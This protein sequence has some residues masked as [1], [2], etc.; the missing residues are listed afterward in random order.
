MSRLTHLGAGAFLLFGMLGKAP[1]RPP[2][3]A[4]AAASA[5][6][7]PPRA[8]PEHGKQGGRLG[9]VVAYVDGT[10]VAVVRRSELPPTM[11]PIALPKLDG[12]N[13]ARYFRLY[14]YVA[15]LGVDPTKVRA[16][17]LHGTRDRVATIEGAELARFKDALVFDFSQET[18]GKPR[19]RWS[20]PALAA[21]V[22]IDQFTA[23]AVYLRKPVP[24]YD[25]KT[26]ALLVEGSPA[27][28][29]PFA[30]DRPGGTRVYL[31]GKLVGW[32]KRKLLGDDLVTPETTRGQTVYDLSAF[33]A[34]LG[35]DLR[36][37]RTVD[38]VDGDDLAA[39]F[40]ARVP[41]AV[42]AT[43]WLPERS[44]GKVMI[45]LPGAGTVQISS[46]QVFARATPPARTVAPELG[47]DGDPEP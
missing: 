16:V 27:S 11:A 26:G 17:E 44:M 14:D 24:H 19:A 33:L 28:G 35:V 40:D 2:S 25:P 15:A 46:I 18:R 29:V 37:A 5:E 32:V 9:E 30:T 42:P 20:I 34:K 31:D 8:P 38:L 36:A 4:S 13:V 39:R 47:E 1:D 22:Q 7:G 23:L 10:P 21:P 3:A 45:D 41:G 6:P 12:L 43:F